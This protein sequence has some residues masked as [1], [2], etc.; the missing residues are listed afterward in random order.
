[1]RTLG[2]VITV[3]LAALCGC[4][5]QEDLRSGEYKT[6]PNDPGRNGQVARENNAKAVEHLQKD[7]LSAAEKELSAALTADMF[8]GPAHNNLGTVY[9]RQKKYYQAAW[10]FQY[11]AKLMPNK[12]EPRNNLGMVFEA[13]GK[14]DDAAKHYEEALQ[15]EPDTMEV[16]GNLAHVYVRANRKDDRT[17]KLLDEIVMK[18]TRLDWITWAREKLAALPQATS[19][20]SR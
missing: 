12:A 15:I 2:L 14:L 7:D 11:A 4:Q 9:Y 18:D 10:E 16:V 19:R 8:F 6:L 5:K 17:R 1:M 13:V 3:M 20:E